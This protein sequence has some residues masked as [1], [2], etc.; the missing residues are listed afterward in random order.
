LMERVPRPAALLSAPTWS[1]PGSPW[2]KRRS[3]ASED[4]TS[5]KSAGAAG[6][7]LR[8]VVTNPA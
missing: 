8:G 2:R 1:T 6:A 4:V 5:V 7:V 3:D